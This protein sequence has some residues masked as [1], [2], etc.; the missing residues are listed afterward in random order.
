MRCRRDVGVEHLLWRCRRQRTLEQ[1]PL[2]RCGRQR[3][4]A[5]VGGGGDRLGCRLRDPGRSASGRTSRGSRRRPGT[6]R[7]PAPV[8]DRASPCAKARRSVAVA[9]VD[10]HSPARQPVVPVAGAGRP[11]RSA[12]HPCTWSTAGG[13][14]GRVRREQTTVLEHDPVE[15]R[16]PGFVD[17]L[18]DGGHLGAQ[19]E[20]VWCLRDA[21]IVVTTRSAAMTIASARVPTRAPEYARLRTDHGDRLL[22]RAGSRRAPS[23]RC[24]PT[25]RGPAA[26]T[27]P[28]L[29]RRGRPP[30]GPVRAV[31]PSS[32]RWRRGCRC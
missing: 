17:D 31:A 20:Q 15:R 12:G 26:P 4:V 18:E 13:R 21:R 3:R 1:P 24:T 8:R 14:A 5:L 28:S 9:S 19:G 10:L 30:S 16:G 32:R 27:W 2:R 29:R 7:R 6:P 25:P 11:T 23:P 22:A